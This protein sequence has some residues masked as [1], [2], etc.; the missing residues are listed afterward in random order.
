LQIRRL[1][2]TL[3]AYDSAHERDSTLGLDQT[4]RTLPALQQQTPHQEGHS[5]EEAGDRPSF[6]L[7]LMRSHLRTRPAGNPKQDLS[8]SGN[9]EAIT[10][11]DRGNTLAETADKISSRHG[12]QVAPSTISRWV[13]E[14]PA[15]TTYRRLRDG[16]RRLF[17]PTQVIRTHKL[18][19]RQVYEFAYPGFLKLHQFMA[20]YEAGNG[21]FFGEQKQIR[22][23][24]SAV[25]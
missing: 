2:G 5:Q 19:H 11:F 24:R 18:Y 22:S 21:G 15:L 1:D 7:P 12:H 14:H 25:V 3:P 16:G 8:P 20:P 23:G 9:L 10:L 17:T 13:P 6:S 4:S